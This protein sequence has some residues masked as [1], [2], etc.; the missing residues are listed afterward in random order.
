MNRDQLLDEAKSLIN[1]D[2]AD[3]YGDPTVNHVR[4]ARMWSAYLGHDISAHDVAI[5]FIL[6]KVSRLA[7]SASHMDSY[8]D[9]AGYAA[10]AAE[11][12]SA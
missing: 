1:G 7:A 12:E 5:C 8:I 9:I 11:F 6:T 3:I 10:L 4:I 2:R